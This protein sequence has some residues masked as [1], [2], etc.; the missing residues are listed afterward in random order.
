MRIGDL[1]VAYDDVGEGDRPLVLV[2][3][4]TGH[5]HDFAPR[6]DELA[7]L[8]RTVVPDLRGHGASGHGEPYTFDQLQADLLGLLDALEIEACDL[9]GHSMGGMLTLRFA[10]AH[11]ARVHSL[12]CMNTA[13]RAPDGIPREAFELAW[14]LARELGMVKLQE[15]VQP[16]IEEDPTRSA[17]DA[18]LQAEWGEERYWQRHRDRFH[19][20]DPEA[21]AGLGRAMLEQESLLPRL[22]ELTLPALVMV[23]ALDRNFL[24]AADELAAGLPEA[25]R[26]TIPEAGHQPQLETPGAWLDAIRGHLQR[27]RA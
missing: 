15:L 12:V 8:G 19:P 7:R 5:R 18:R 22:A 14:K 4:W 1:E 13:A 17:A 16:R 11:P 23:G 21:Y 6:L 3:G 2:H 24:A 20:M 10:L 27:V 9:L 26:V 25:E